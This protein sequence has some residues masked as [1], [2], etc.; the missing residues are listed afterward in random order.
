MQKKHKKCN[1]FA[2]MTDWKPPPGYDQNLR[3][4]YCSWCDEKF[5]IRLGDKQIIKL[6]IQ[7]E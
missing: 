2:P 1:N 5:Y 4:F 3:E 7:G 6:K